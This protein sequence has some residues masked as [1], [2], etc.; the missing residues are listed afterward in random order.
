MPGFAAGSISPMAG[1]RPQDLFG[2]DRTG[3]P[4]AGGRTRGRVRPTLRR[5]SIRRSPPL[6]S[7]RGQGP[8][9]ADFEPGA[10][11]IETR[12]RLG[13]HRVQG[14][15]RG[16]AEARED[17]EG[18]STPG[19]ISSERILSDRRCYGVD[20]GKFSDRL[21]L[22]IDPGGRGLRRGKNARSPPGFAPD[23]APMSYGDGSDQGESAGTVNDRH[24]LVS[25]FVLPG[26]RRFVP[27]R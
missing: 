8:G 1:A 9:R 15:H 19:A 6:S 11:E 21:R 5:L 25:D 4:R 26:G 18:E 22:L 2:V 23:P 10:Q 13:E 16:Q 12:H 20:G 17:R 14:H 27:D 3:S 24:R 7:S